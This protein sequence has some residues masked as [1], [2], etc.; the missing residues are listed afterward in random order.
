LSADG[1][2]QIR[3]RKP[4]LMSRFCFVILENHLSMDV[5]APKSLSSQAHLALHG[6]A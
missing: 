4:Q 5:E 6:R 2:V 1:L 3:N